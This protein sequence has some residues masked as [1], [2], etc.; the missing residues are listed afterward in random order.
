MDERTE[1]THWVINC[2]GA[3]GDPR[4]SNNPLIRRL[5]QRGLAKPD[6]LDLGLDADAES[7]LLDASG[8]AQKDLFGI[9][10]I[11]RGAFWEVVAVPDLRI[12][13]QHVAAAIS[14]NGG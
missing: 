1:R 13:A 14:A 12:Q 6:P 5:L 9:G 4:S 8:L 2:T 3:E 11:T 10:P 7:R